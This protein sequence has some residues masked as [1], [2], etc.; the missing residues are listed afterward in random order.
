MEYEQFL[1]LVEARRSIRTFKLDP[2]PI[3]AVEKILEAA[4]WAPSGAN[5]QPWEFIVVRDPAVKNQFVKVLTQERPPRSEQ[6]ENGASRPPRQR[7]Q[8]FKDASVFIVVCGDTRRKIFYPGTR[9]EVENGKITAIDNPMINTESV[10]TSS[11]ANAFLYLQLAVKTMGLGSQWITATTR[12]QIQDEL[13][14]LLKIPEHMVIYDTVALGYPAVSPDQRTPRTLAEITHHDRYD[15]SKSKTDNELI[16]LV[17]ARR[18]S[19]RR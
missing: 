9:F 2:V 6:G 3:E 8:G 4:R 19:R 17:K 15:L 18:A 14:K 16:E 1:E 10:F 13:K 7:R 11:L 12:P 5:S